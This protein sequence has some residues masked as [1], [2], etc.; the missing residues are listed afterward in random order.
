MFPESLFQAKSHTVSYRESEW[1]TLLLGALVGHKMN[2]LKFYDVICYKIGF[3]HPPTCNVHAFQ[4][5]RN[6]ALGVEGGISPSPLQRPYSCCGHC[7][8]LLKK[9]LYVSCGPSPAFGVALAERL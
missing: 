8:P 5:F 3:M 1:Q 7:L 6:R 4:Q 9:E 2:S